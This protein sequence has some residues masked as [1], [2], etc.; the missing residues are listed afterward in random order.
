MIIET[1][2]RRRTP[3]TYTKALLHFDGT[4]GSTTFTDETGKI[5]TA[6]LTYLETSY[7]KFG[8]SCGFIGGLNAGSYLDTPSVDDFAFGSNDFTIDFQAYLSNTNIIHKIRFGTVATNWLDFYFLFYQSIPAWSLL[9][10]YNVSE[11]SSPTAN[12]P[13][14]DWSYSN[15]WNHVAIVFSNGNT[16]KTYINGI[17]NGTASFSYNIPAYKCTL[18]GGDIYGGYWDEFRIS[19]GIQRWTSDFTPPTS[20]Y[21]LD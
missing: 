17:L 6:H 20:A 11:F 10:Y 15:A 18:L 19:K 5:W 1:M 13:L 9:T 2:G 14:S 7:K 3:E 8:V 21:T 16:M 4:D 12:F